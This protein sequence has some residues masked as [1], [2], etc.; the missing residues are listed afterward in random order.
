MSA[1]NKS[2][3]NAYANNRLLRYPL[4]FLV[5]VF[6]CILVCGAGAFYLGHR[7]LATHSSP[8]D[9]VSLLAALDNSIFA[10][11]PSWCRFELLAFSQTPTPKLWLMYT[12]GSTLIIVVLI[13]LTLVLVKVARLVGIHHHAIQADKP[14]RIKQ[15]LQEI[16]FLLFWLSASLLLLIIFQTAKGENY[17]LTYRDMH[18]FGMIY[19]VFSFCIFIIAFDCWFYFIHRLMHRGWLYQLIHSTHHLSTKTGVLTQ[20]QFSPL[21]IVPTL[22]F[23]EFLLPL[24]LPL[25]PDTARWAMYAIYLKVYLAHSGYEVFPERFTSSKFCRWLVTNTHHDLHHS[26]YQYNYAI[27]FT[28][29][30]RW[31]AT[32][33]PLYRELHVKATSK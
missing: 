33:H 16:S 31:F 18:Q 9:H 3:G 29:W 2:K 15:F 1:S 7:E 32:E 22:V 25:H 19:T 17:G 6:L 4:N 30:D 11:F 24:V 28:C 23:T 20:L 21:E 12:F 26:S 8:A 13:I 5:Q 10:H 27:F 14:W